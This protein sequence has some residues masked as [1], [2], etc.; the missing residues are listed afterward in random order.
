MKIMLI[1]KYLHI[2]CFIESKVSFFIFI[3]K[4]I[5]TRLFKV[6]II[7]S[8]YFEISAAPKSSEIK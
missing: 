1:F 4:E 3:W 5:L 2:F 8:P 7:D 6:N